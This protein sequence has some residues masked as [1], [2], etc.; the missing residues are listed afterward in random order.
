MQ[1]S[2]DQQTLLFVGI[3]YVVAMTLWVLS[4]QARA[5]TTLGLLSEL[6]EPSLWQALGAPRSMKAI[7]QDPE[8]RWARFIRSGE[9]RRQCDETAIA[10]IDDYRQRT[11]VML[12]VFA[13]SG[14]L[15]L[16]R[17]WPVLKPEI[18]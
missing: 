7:M 5:R 10:L 8:R 12:G 4:L 16:V 13:I 9:Y 6:I 3:G 14:I 17:F 1:L 18:F 15:L 11:R 2:A